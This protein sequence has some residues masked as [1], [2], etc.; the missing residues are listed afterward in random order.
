MNERHLIK[1][2]HNCTIKIRA[3]YDSLKT[4]ERK[5]V[6][7]LLEHPDEIAQLT[8]V[9]FADQAGCSEATIVRLSKRLGYEGF[10][11]LKADFSTREVSDEFEYE[12]ISKNDDDQAV[13][14][15]VFEATIRALRDTLEVMDPAA[16]KR[17]IDALLKADKIMFSGVGDAAIVAIE[18]SQRFLRIGE[19]AM[20]SQDVDVELILSSQL[21]KDDVLIAISHSGR[22]KSV[23][24]CVRIAKKMGATTVAITNFPISPVAKNVDIILLTAAFSKQSMTGEVM[25]KR[26]AELCIIESLYTHYL[27][28]KGKIARE[29]LKRSNEVVSINKL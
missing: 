17:A 4:A 25:S 21:S 29:R 24:D 19:N 16:Y 20:A 13:V 27:L 12:D 14:R 2:P 1:I 18:A 9:D 22:S 23:L 26:V 3:V 28:Q 11:E 7:F 15:K 10:P 5:A 6:D 8:I